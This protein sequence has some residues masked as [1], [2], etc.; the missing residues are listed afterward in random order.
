MD[1]LEAS[2]IVPFSVGSDKRVG[3]SRSYLA[4]FSGDTF[5][6]VQITGGSINDPVNGIMMEKGVHS[7]F[8]GYRFGVEC[9]DI[10]NSPVPEYRVRLV[11]NNLP[12]SLEGCDGRFLHFGQWETT[13]FDEPSYTPLPSKAYLRTHLAIA[14]VLHAGSF[15]RRRMRWR[16]LLNVAG[17]ST[18]MVKNSM[19]EAAGVLL[20]LPVD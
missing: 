15:L 18:S 16:G 6:K 5:R 12:K 14:K 1:T 2:H 9:T 8:S 11:H 7:A 4:D 17:C 3:A 10:P 13:Q 20:L 19:K